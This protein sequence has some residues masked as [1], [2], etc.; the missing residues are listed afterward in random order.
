MASLRQPRVF[1]DC[2]GCFNLSWESK[3]GRQFPN[4]E[5]RV[6]ILWTDWATW[7]NAPAAAFILGWEETP[8]Q[9]QGLWWKDWWGG[10]T[11]IDDIEVEPDPAYTHATEHF[12]AF[13]SIDGHPSWTW[14]GNHTA[15]T[16]TP[17]LLISDRY[18]KDPK[19][20]EVWHG[21]LQAGVFKSV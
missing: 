12:A 1:D 18:Y 14:D 5:T 16:L 6:G 9:P 15:P 2:P 17:S 7:E 4:R 13:K 19:R 21:F 3:N 11:V 8:G 10:I 20:R